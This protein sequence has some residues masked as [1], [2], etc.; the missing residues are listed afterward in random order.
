MVANPKAPS[1]FLRPYNSVGGRN[2]QPM[3]QTELI[4][5]LVDLAD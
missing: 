3:Y 1:D 5:D 4:S 2:V